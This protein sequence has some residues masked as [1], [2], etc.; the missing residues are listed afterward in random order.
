MSDETDAGTANT[1]RER[2]DE[3]GLK[4]WVLLRANRLH[5]TSALT[6][7]VFVAFVIAVTTLPPPFTQQIASGDMIDTMFST[8]IAVIVTGTTLVV[9]IGQLVL[10]QENGPLGDQRERM[11]N[12]MDF[13]EFTQEMIGSPTPTD[14]SAFLGEL[15]G[16]T[17]Q[18]TTALGEAVDENRDEGLRAEV[19]EFAE[20]L[21]ENAEVVREQLE[22][23]QFGSF[24]V[25]F[26]ALNFEYSSKIFQTERIASEYEG[27]LTETELTLL[28][29]LKT[30]LSVFGPAREHVKTLYFQW[31]LIELSQLIL[32]AAVPALAVAG[33]MIG[34]VDAGTVPGA[35]FGIDHIALVVGG[36]FALTLLPFMLLVSYVLRILTVAK[37]TLAIEPL[38]LRDSGR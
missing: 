1:M 28:D 34:I 32:Y 31:A 35:T 19:G 2:A 10:S 4:L 25:V 11:S 17:T 5:L 27:S 20:T 22:G 16:V 15:I 13:R 29:D 38:I 36:A 24:D 9:T 14:P 7:G 37:R 8:M 3:S 26:A 18:R 30:A 6:G 12:A 21:T 23:A 33:I